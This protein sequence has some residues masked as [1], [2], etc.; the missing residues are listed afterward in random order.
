M[1]EPLY[2]FDKNLI[3]KDTVYTTI[4][5]WELSGLMEFENLQPFWAIS[6]YCYITAVTVF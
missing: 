5:C 3:L 6:L 2:L 1:E 4:K